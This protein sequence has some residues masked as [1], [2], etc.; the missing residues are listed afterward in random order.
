MSRVVLVCGGR[1]YNDQE[2]LFAALDARL[3]PDD[4]VVQG[5]AEGADRLARHWCSARG[6][7][8]ATVPALW[9]NFKRGAG[10]RRN[11]AML[12]LRPDEVLAFPGGRGTDM[13]CR[14]AEARGVPVTR[15][16][17]HGEADE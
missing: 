9:K 2:A 16:P 11:T 8:Y 1:D 10:F 3:S 15:L 4:I 12:L 14:L 5:G 17:P 6:V 7:H 13:M